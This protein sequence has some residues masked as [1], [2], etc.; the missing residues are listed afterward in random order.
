MVDHGVE[1]GWSGISSWRSGVCGSPCLS[2][3]AG[4]DSLSLS[5]QTKEAKKGA[6]DG[7]FPLNFCRAEG[8][9]ANSLRADKPPFSFLPATGIQGAI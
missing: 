9:E 8:R 4:A 5:C 1:R 6:R 7:D 2:S 3:P